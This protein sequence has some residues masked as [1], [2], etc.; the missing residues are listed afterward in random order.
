MLDLA[1]ATDVQSLR[2]DWDFDGDGL[3]SGG[4]QDAL[5]HVIKH[6]PALRSG[7]RIVGHAELNSRPHLLTGPVGTVLNVHFCGDH[8]AMRIHDFARERGLGL[9]LVPDELMDKYSVRRRD[10]STM[11]VYAPLRWKREWDVWG[12]RAQRKVRFVLAERRWR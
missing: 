8:K 6:D 10:V 5:W 3:F 11:R 4:D 1:Q 12:T 7:T 9:E 2:A